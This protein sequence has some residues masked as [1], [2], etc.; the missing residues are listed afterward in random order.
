MSLY[1]LSY[2]LGLQ[3]MSI[4]WGEF[5]A[6]LGRKMMEL[7]ADDLQACKAGKLNEVSVVKLASLGTGGKYPGNVW[8]DL[9]KLLP[10]PKL[11][12]LHYLWLHMSFLCM[13]LIPISSYTM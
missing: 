9:K 12:K 10:E 4:L 1:Q 2:I 11:P 13:N 6:N 3:V 7:L 8:R 5:S